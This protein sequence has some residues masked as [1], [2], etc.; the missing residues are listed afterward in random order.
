M[1]AR[2]SRHLL[3]LAALAATAAAAVTD[4]A[5]ASSTTTTAAAEATACVAH[6]ASGA[7]F[8]LRPDTAIVVEKDGP[9]TPKT[10]KNVPTADYIARG[11]EMGFNFTLNICGP[12]VKPVDEVV[13]LK[14]AEYRNVSAYY[15]Q[16]G[17]VYSVGY[18]HLRGE[19][20]DC[21]AVLTLH[22][23]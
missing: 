12:V 15:E 18:G 23:T 5:S 16:G 2:T 22:Q 8:D 13:G 21:M 19:C 9:K 17:K 11:Y 14:K 10:P 7:F 20:E 6:S 1:L 3:V 4:K